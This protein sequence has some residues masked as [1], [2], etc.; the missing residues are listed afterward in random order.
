[1]RRGKTFVICGPSGVGKGTVIGKL[2]AADPTLYFSVSATTRAPRPGEEEGVHYH[3]LSRD[4]FRAW[5]DQDAFLEYDEHFDNL[6]G[7]PKR[8]VDEAMAAGRDV[9]LDIDIKGAA[10]VKARRPETVRIFIAP[11]SWAELERRL[12]RRGTEDR[13]RVLARLARS[14]EELAAAGE[15]DYLLINDR[16]DRA[17]LELFSIMTAEHC[18]PADR[19]DEVK[20]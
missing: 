14:R 9:L 13:E 8:Y 12:L 20:Q 6:Y 1:M 11:P 19:I 15:F 4:T 3:F 16:A 7:T 17:A 10:Q 5:I 18:R 2:L